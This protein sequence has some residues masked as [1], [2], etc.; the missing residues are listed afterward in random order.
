[1]SR[2]RKSIKSLARVSLSYT[3]SRLQCS[4]SHDLAAIRATT[5]CALSGVEAVSIFRIYVE[6]GHCAGFWVQHRTWRNIC[7]QVQSIAGKQF[8]RLPGVAPMHEG[9]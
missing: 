3:Y 6:N 2:H 9:A 7:A 5:D 8:G 1:M 4:L